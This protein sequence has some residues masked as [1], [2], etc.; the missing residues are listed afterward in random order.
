[1]KAK[2]FDVVLHDVPSGKSP[3]TH[4]EDQMNNFFKHYQNLQVFA[5]HMNTVTVPAEPATPTQEAKPASVV[6]FATL[7]YTT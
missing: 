7:F 4:L 2:I 5:T 6:I 3:A 1:M